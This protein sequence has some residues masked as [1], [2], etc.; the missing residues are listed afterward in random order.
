NAKGQGGM[1]RKQ[2]DKIVEMARGNGAKGL[3]Y[4]SLKE[5]GSVKCSFAKF[6]SEEEIKALVDRMGG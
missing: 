5:D 2:I 3:P 6:V 1:G 4:I